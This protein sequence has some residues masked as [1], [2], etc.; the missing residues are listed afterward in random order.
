MKAF[1]LVLALAVVAT[2]SVRAEAKLD[3]K[4]SLSLSEDKPINAKCPVA[5]KDVKADC[6]TKYKDHV[7]A[8]C[9]GN[10]KGKFEKEPEKYVKNI[11]ELKEKK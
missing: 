10:C 9:C 8:F 3:S 7:I 5:N 1:A 6:T 4:S 11:P 2:A